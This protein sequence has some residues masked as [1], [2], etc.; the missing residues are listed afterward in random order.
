MGTDVRQQTLDLKRRLQQQGGKYSFFQALRLL[1]LISAADNSSQDAV[2]RVRPR[3]ALGFPETDLEKIEH[4]TSEKWRVTANF[5]GLYGVDSPLPTFYTEDLLVEQADGLS[6]NREF[7]DIPAQSIYPLFYQAWL[8]SKPALRVLEYGDQRMLQILYS[9]VGLELDRG[10]LNRPAVGSLLICG[11]LYNQQ[12]RTAL[13]LKTILTACFAGATVEI[14]ELEPTT[15]SIPMPQRCRLGMVA[16]TLGENAHLG[17]YCRS[18]D[19]VV[20][21]MSDLTSELYFSLMPSGA[22]HSRLCFLVD[23]YLIEAL[24]VRVELTLQEGQV[25]PTQLS[26]PIWSRLGLDSWLVTEH[27]SPNASMSFSL[28]LRK[29]TGYPSAVNDTDL[30]DN[31]T[32]I[33][34]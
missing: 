32:E 5:L 16:S 7:L 15:D 4:E 33:F 25:T 23:Y 26:A 1:R 14:R 2:V 8:K 18:L 20:I 6:V 9:F 10:Q 11:S 17:E 12:T 21:V 27:Q 22:A 31:G 24:P 28:Q 34:P 30:V 13:G 19:G 3:L 29:V